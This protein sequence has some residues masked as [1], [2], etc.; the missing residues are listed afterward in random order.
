MGNTRNDWYAGVVERDQ[1]KK[2]KEAACL[3]R[4]QALM[5]AQTLRAERLRLEKESH[6]LRTKKNDLKTR[7]AA[8]Y[9]EL[10]SSKKQ[11]Q[12]LADERKEMATAFCEVQQHLEQQL[13]FYEQLHREDQT[14]RKQLV[15]AQETLAALRADNQHVSKENVA[16]QTRCADLQQ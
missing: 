14:L 2:E 15:E 5:E 16:L 10:E 6:R 1:L 9:A 12:V 11:V 7:L 3:Q 13:T 4:D 8:Y